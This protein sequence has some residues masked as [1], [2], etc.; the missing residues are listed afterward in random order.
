[1]TKS[2]RIGANLAER[3]QPHLTD[4]KREAATSLSARLSRS[5]SRAARLLLTTQQ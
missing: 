4:D 3:T 2:T 1:M 5:M